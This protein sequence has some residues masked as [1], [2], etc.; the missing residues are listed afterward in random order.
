MY[1]VCS[2]LVAIIALTH[3]S[4]RY[5]CHPWKS[6][7]PMILQAPIFVSFFLAI[8]RMAVLPSFE[9]GGPALFANLAV[10]DPTY[11]L[12]LL[13]GATF[14]ATV[15]VRMLYLLRFFS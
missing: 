5:D 14:L 2:Q 15:E 8:K 6:F 4:R 12:P 1:S 11:M 3:V 13:S 10:A 9:T 7:A